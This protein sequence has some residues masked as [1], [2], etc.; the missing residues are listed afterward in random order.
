MLPCLQAG[1]LLDQAV[2]RV[3]L[4]SLIGLVIPIPVV[5]LVDLVF[6]DDIG[7]VEAVPDPGRRGGSPQR[8]EYVLK[9]CNR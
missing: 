9:Y 1:R 4:V 3:D 5:R 6:I 7:L 8:R 2:P